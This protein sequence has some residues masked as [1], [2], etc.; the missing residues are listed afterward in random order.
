MRHAVPDLE[1]HPA[2]GGAIAS[3]LLLIALCTYAL[4]LLHPAAAPKLC[5]R[6]LVACLT[7]RAF[8]A[9]AQGPQVL[10]VAH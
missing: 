3:L 6:E 5:R 7:H 2:A 9:A 8:Q 10:L 4:G 1:A